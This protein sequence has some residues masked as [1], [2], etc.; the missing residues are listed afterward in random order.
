MAVPEGCRPG[1]E[2]R[3]AG[4]TDF[5]IVVG[6]SAVERDGR[7]PAGAGDTRAVLHAGLGIK[8][9]PVMLGPLLILGVGSGSPGPI[10][11]GIIAVLSRL[12]WEAPFWGVSRFTGNERVVSLIVPALGGLHRQ[13]GW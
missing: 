12:A 9:V 7:G 2:G 13:P 11:A 10:G 3:A 6:L 8:A 5:R 4:E 1:G